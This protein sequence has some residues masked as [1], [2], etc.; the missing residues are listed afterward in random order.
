[1][2]G[3]GERVA[4]DHDVDD[5]GAAPMTRPRFADRAIGRPP[6]ASRVRP[7]HQP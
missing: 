7:G 3:K 2:R 6:L 1:M 4:V 5:D